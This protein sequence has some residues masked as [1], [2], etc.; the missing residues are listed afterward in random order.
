MNLF[1]SELLNRDD[2]LAK[3]AKKKLIEPDHLKALF[4]KTW[5]KSVPT[6]TSIAWYPR[7][8]K[9]IAFLASPTSSWSS[10]CYGK[11][12][13]NASHF[14]RQLLEK[15]PV[16]CAVESWAPLPNVICLLVRFMP[17]NVRS[18]F[19]VIYQAWDAVF[20]H[21]RELKIRHAAE[22]FWRTSRSPCFLWWRD[23]VSNAWY[24]FSNK[25]ILQGEF[26]DAKMS[27]FSSDFQ[28]LIK[29]WFP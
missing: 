25:V 9:G 29:H 22:Y 19:R 23:T 21:Q 18:F 26:K 2:I 15:E 11:V 5:Y 10:P 20:H 3:F 13:N 7:Q 8:V 24:Y 17:W 4:S 12:P 16:F 1:A 14:F 6:Y 27:S 28:T